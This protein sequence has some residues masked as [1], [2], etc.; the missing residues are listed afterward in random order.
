MNDQKLLQK[1]YGHLGAKIIRRRL[2]DLRAASTLEDMRLLPGKYHELKENRK[3]QIA[4]HVEEPKR[5]IFIPDHEPV[6][7]TSNGA[8]NWKEVRSIKV[9]EIVNYH[10]K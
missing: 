10:G 9:L 4:V 7:L 5:L 3:G 1:E 2:D 6:P 8:I